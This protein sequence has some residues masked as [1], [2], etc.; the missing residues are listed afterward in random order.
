MVAVGVATFW[1][2]NST[3]VLTW[4]D[5]PLR[6]PGSLPADSKTPLPTAGCIE[7]GRYWA[8]VQDALPVWWAVCRHPGVL[9]ALEHGIGPVS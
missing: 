2:S 1:G 6:T 7:P 8:G 9:G 5:K 4:A 3:M